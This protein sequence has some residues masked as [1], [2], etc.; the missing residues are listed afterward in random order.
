[1]NAAISLL[2]PES[3]CVAAPQVTAEMI[4]P[5]NNSLWR[6]PSAEEWAH[7]KEWQAYKPVNLV[8]TSRRVFTGEFPAVSISSFGLLTLI[9]ALVANICARERYSP[10]MAPILDNEY[11]AR[12]ERSLHAWETLWR[13]H[14][15]AEG[16]QGMRSDPLM[17]ECLC[18]LSSAYHHL[19]MGQELQILKRIAKEPECHL[20]IPN[21]PTNK[22]VLSVIKYAATSWLADTMTGIGHRQRKAA[23]EFGGLGPMS[24]YE[25]GKQSR[26]KQ[27]YQELNS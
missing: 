26:S 6:A 17:T 12:M 20:S 23:C 13:S 4:V 3:T 14:P 16:T 24:A 22:K 1:M 8:E 5:S 21:L 15:H 10:E 18:L 11:C 9:G 7:N 19:Y 27:S 2:D 25:A